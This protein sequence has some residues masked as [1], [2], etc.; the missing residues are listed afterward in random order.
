MLVTSS[1]DKFLAFVQV[2]SDASLVRVTLRFY[3]K[4]FFF[5]LLLTKARAESGDEIGN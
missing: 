3:D 2:L 4:F 1:P 5:F